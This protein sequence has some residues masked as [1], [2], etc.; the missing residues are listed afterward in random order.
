MIKMGMLFD[1]LP[2]LDGWEYR[3]EEVTEQILPAGGQYD[4][5]FAEKELGWILNAILGVSGPN[6]EKTRISIRV[7]GW[8]I[9]MTFEEL[10]QSGG[11]QRGVVTPYLSRYDTVLN[12]YQGFF[13]FPYPMPY[14]SFLRVTVTGPSE[15]AIL[16]NGKA[17]TV[18]IKPLPGMKEKFE[19]SLRKVLGT[20]EIA[21][22]IAKAMKV[23]R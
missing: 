22:E 16:I 20:S 12:I 15:N 4:I 21:A 5:I 6:A 13:E 17:A 3:L 10:Y 2:F 23:G 9:A 19:R 7:D 1:L 8:L 18:R 14:K 11:V